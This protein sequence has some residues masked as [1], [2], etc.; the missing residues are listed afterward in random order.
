MFGFKNTAEKNAQKTVQFTMQIIGQKTGLDPTKLPNE[1]RDRILT[2]TLKGG[3]D[4]KYDF[5]AQYMTGFAFVLHGMKRKDE[6]DRV[7]HALID[8]V[9]GNKKNMTLSAYDEC[10]AIFKSAAPQ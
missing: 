7:L 2:N 9:E 1:L 6:S 4:N 3:T 10:Q 8:F 5:C